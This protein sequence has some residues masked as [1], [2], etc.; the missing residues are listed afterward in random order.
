[1]LFRQR[2]TMVCSLLASVWLHELKNIVSTLEVQLCVCAILVCVSAQPC[3]LYEFALLGKSCLTLT[4][5]MQ[6]VY[7]CTD[8]QKF[9]VVSRG[10]KRGQK[11]TGACLPQVDKQSEQHK[12]TMATM[13]LRTQQTRPFK[14]SNESAG[15][16][17]C[18]VLL[19]QNWLIIWPLCPLYELP[20]FL[21]KV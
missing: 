17:V 12:G 8:E 6:L 1:M 11:A 5:L 20:P 19:I 10:L 13:L 3:G 14:M 15:A 16:R 4:F 18:S 9:A 21:Y 2:L 7:W